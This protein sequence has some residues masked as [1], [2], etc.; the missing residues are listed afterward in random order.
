MNQRESQYEYLLKILG[1]VRNARRA[2]RDQGADE[3]LRRPELLEPL[4]ELVFSEN[5]DLSVKAAWIMELVCLEEIRLI[6]P[7]RH[8]FSLGLDKLKDESSLRPAAKICSLLSGAY[9]SGPWEPFDPDSEWINAMI[10]ASFDWLTGPHKVATRVFAM[11]TL[12]HWG[13]RFDWIHA[14]LLSLL[15]QA[16]GEASPGYRSR[17]RKIMDKIHASRRMKRQN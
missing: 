2:Y 5:R 4:V 13:N 12:Y 8:T 9:E 1:D 10:S 7:Y 6:I 14:E 11:E 16:Y 15:D 17:A 3:I